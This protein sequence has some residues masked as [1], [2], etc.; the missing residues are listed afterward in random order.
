MRGEA[1][2]GARRATADRLGALAR[3]NRGEV[4][5]RLHIPARTMDLKLTNKVALVTRA[6]SGLGLAIAR[7]LAVEGASVAIVARRKAELEQG[8]AD[9]LKVARTRVLPIVGDVT[10]PGE[11][12][13]IAREAESALGPIGILLANAGG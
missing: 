12:D 13:R 4:S 5:S 9:I 7:E 2:A 1:D 10:K 8:A 11:A 3:T 6:S